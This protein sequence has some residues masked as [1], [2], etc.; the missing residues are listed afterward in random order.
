MP[1]VRSKKDIDMNK[2]EFDTK[3][4]HNVQQDQLR[5]SKVRKKKKRNKIIRRF[6]VIFLLLIIAACIGAYAYFYATDSFKIQ[7]IKINGVSHLTQDEM[8]QLIDI[9][10]DATLLKVDT[11]TIVKRLKRDAWIKDVQIGMEFPSTL[12]IN[13]TERDI[14]AIVEVPTTTTATD[15]QVRNWAISSDH[16]WLMP[17]PDKNSEAAKNIN[18]QIYADLEG[19]MHIVDVSP[20]VQPEISS[21]CTDEPVNCAIDVVSAMTTDLKNQVKYV[22]ATDANSTNLFLNNGVEIAVGNSE[23]LREKERVAQELLSK[24]DGK[25]SYINVRNPQNPTWRSI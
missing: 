1:K 21:Y 15:K 11:D 22:K 7:N 17:I 19:V 4:P 18:Q 24:Y 16:M 25:I 8:D 9:P 14:A 6:V 3:T 23:N 5:R 12:V 13:I 20:S 2:V 10:E